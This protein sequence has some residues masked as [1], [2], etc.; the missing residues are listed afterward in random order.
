MEGGSGSVYIFNSVV[1]LVRLVGGGDHCGSS[2]P[3]VWTHALVL[4]QWA[5]RWESGTV[6]TTASDEARLHYIQASDGYLHRPCPS[7]GATQ[8]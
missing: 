7:M 1:G 4:G 6:I 8:H 3:S 5:A 2:L